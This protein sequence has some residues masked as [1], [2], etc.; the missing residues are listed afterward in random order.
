MRRTFV[1]SVSLLLL[2]FVCWS[3]H[4]ENWPRF[5]GSNGDGQSEA[6]GIPVEWKT[7]EYTWKKPLSGVGR[8]SPV[9]WNDRLFVT[10]A[11]GDNGE[12]ILLAFDARTGDQ[13]WEKRFPSAT[14]KQHVENSYATSTPAV[15]ANRLYISWLD[16]DKITLGA[17]TH[18]G[19]EIWRR[20]VGTLIEQHGYGTSPVVIGDVVCLDCETE[21][22]DDS[23]VTGLDAATGDIRWHVPRGTGKTVF[24]TPCVW[25]AGTANPLLVT[26]SMGSGLTAFEP[27]SGQIVW[28]TV[29]NDLPDR[30][31]SSPIVAGGLVFVS[32]GSGNNGL[33]LIAIRPNDDGQPPQE[34][35]RLEVG[36]PNIPTPV[37][38]GDLL[39]M[40][41][42]RGTVSCVDLATGEEHW[43][44]RVKGKFHSSP[45]RVGDRIYCVSLDGDVV[46]IAAS[47]EYKLLGRS[48]LEEPVQATPA[49]ANN[50]I[51]FRTDASLICLGQT[52]T[53]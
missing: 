37:V 3:S 36:V 28:Q 9:I 42:D 50:R 25:G 23:I 44:Q 46:V 6:I 14:H 1:F 45:V 35:Y 30:C 32:C 24:A 21:N 12:Q 10:S 13:L 31:V 29:E 5:R 52:E 17:F 48:A 22:K 27:L 43:R 38:A 18:Q 15:D 41:H 26:A 8:S 4:G 40:W 34:A 51:Y 20:Q 11:N 33:R 16:G 7:G 53:N 39:F 2:T 19:E 47:K 49:V